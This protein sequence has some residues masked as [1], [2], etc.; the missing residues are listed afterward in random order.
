MGGQEARP[1][2]GRPRPAPLPGGLSVDRGVDSGGSIP[3]PPR[4]YSR[5]LLHS[6][7]RIVDLGFRHRIES[8]D[9]RATRRGV[10]SGEVSEETYDVLDIAYSVHHKRGADE[11]APTL[12]ACRLSGLFNRVVLGIHLCRT[13]GLCVRKLSHGG[14]TDHWI[15]FSI[16]PTSLF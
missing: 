14:V 5:A 15:P 7:N 16:P 4:A 8:H 11:E 1:C 2:P 12:D 10:I 3:Y 6:A 9:T 13:F